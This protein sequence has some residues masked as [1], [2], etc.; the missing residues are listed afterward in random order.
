MEIKETLSERLGDDLRSVAQG[1]IR[2][3][4]YDVVFLRDDA[5]ELMTDEKR[6]KVFAEVAA[7]NFFGIGTEEIGS[8]LGSLRFTSRVFDSAILVIGWINSDAVLVTVDP[9]NKNIPLIMDVLK[10]I[11][12]KEERYTNE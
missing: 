6:E 5:N 9:D 4:K 2:E 11:F 3:Y 1:N 10:S 7:E 8:T 12:E